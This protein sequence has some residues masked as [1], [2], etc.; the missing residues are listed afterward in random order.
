MR[1]YAAERTRRLEIK[2]LKDGQCIRYRYV[3]DSR[4][5]R[6]RSTVQVE[7]VG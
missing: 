1:G 6:H 4:Q 3:E 7:P 5:V 2:V